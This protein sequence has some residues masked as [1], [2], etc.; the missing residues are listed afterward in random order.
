MLLSD[1]SVRAAHTMA[2]IGLLCGIGTAQTFTKLIAEDDP[3][4]GGVYGGQ[5]SY[6]ETVDI[7]NRGDWA[8]LV[9]ADGGTSLSTCYV[10]VNGVVA[11]E[12][13]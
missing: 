11:F 5:I 13:D 2:L 10:L 7:N 4:P 3:I 6:I 1:I 8:C 9:R 12:Q